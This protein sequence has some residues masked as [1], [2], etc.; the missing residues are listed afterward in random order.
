[1]SDYPTTD[2][3]QTEFH[4]D[5]MFGQPEGTCEWVGGEWWLVKGKS[6]TYRCD[7]R[8]WSCTCPDHQCRR[9]PGEDCKHLSVLRAHRERMGVT[10]SS[11]E[12][13]AAAQVEFSDEELRAIF[14]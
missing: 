8:D 1:M 12:S 2:L 3:D 13:L 4:T 9:V 11:K 6:R 10:E 5:L 7:V 14:A